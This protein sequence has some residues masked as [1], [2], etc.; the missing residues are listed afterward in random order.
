M[1]PLAPAVALSLVLAA[2]P[3]RAAAADAFPPANSSVF[4]PRPPVASSPAPLRL[5]APS[6]GLKQF[7]LAT[8]GTVVT[9][10][11]GLGVTLLS[12]DQESNIF[13]LSVLAA[14]AVAGLVVCG[15]GTW[16]LLYEGRCGAAVAGAYIGG[17]AGLVPGGLLLAACS[18][19]DCLT[20]VV[21]AVIAGYVLGVSTGALVGWNLSRQPKQLPVAEAA[22]PTLQPGQDDLPPAEGERAT[23]ARIVRSGESSP[24]QLVFPVFAAAF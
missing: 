12:K 11:I 20:T 21:V 2:L 23:P 18:S 16:S 1:K 5:D 7:G 24:H 8:L 17:V 22:A 6:L 19:D 13:G 4:A 9:V 15:V 3:G 10:G 14:P